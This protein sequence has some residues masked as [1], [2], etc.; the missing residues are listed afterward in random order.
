M[1]LK[2]RIHCAE[3]SVWDG[4]G[5]EGDGR[6]ATIDLSSGRCVVIK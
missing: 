3:L 6:K 2:K 5:R 4:W 1:L